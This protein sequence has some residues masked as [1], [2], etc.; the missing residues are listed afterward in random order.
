[1]HLYTKESL[2]DL[3]TDESFT[4]ST[5]TDLKKQLQIDLVLRPLQV[6]DYS[7]GYFKLISEESDV[8]IGE[9]SEAK[10]KEYFSVLQSCPGMYYPVV[11]EEVSKAT[12]V[13]AGT[14][15]IE[16]KFIHETALR[17]RI[18]NLVVFQSY[19][20]RGVGSLMLET[21]TKLARQLGCYK[22]TLN[23]SREIMAFCGNCDYAA[24][25]HQNFMLK[26]FTDDTT[27]NNQ[28]S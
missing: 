11:V 1:M 14:L 20:R 28:E 16:Q 7:K 5:Y 19:R 22:T 6:D 2:A 12:V 15:I 18:E 3:L 24:E 26:T 17:G 13:G 27:N 25:D 4:Y 21:L 8:V 9:D 23:C 10:F